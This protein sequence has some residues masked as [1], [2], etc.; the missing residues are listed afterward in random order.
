[1]NQP[2]DQ[3]ARQR[4]L[5]AELSFAVS[6]PAGSGKTGLLTQRV[7]TL[8]A[9]C[10]NPE[11][12]LSIT[13]TR[14]A[15]AEMQT[16]IYNA[17]L[18]A[19]TQP[20]PDNAYA[21][22]TWDLARTVL[23]VSEQK[24]WQILENKNR[25]RVMTIDGLCRT[26]TQQLPISSGL[27]VNL[28]TCDDPELLYQ[29][30][31][32]G[33]LDQLETSSPFQDSIR[34]LF[35][36]LD[37]NYQKIESLLVTLL[38]NRD[39]WLSHLYASKDEKRYLESVLNS[40]VCET[41]ENCHRLLAPVASDLVLLADY[42]ANGLLRDNK[43]S[44]VSTCK[45]LT[46]LPAPT[47]DNLQ[48]W[49]ALVQFLT[50]DAGTWRKTVNK[51]Q[52]FPTGA[53]KEEKA[54]ASLRKSQFYE[55]ISWCSEQAGLNELLA[56][57]RL[58]PT[59]VYAEHQWAFLDSLTQVLPLLVAQLKVVFNQQKQVD[60]IE[61]TQAALQALGDQDEPTD[62]ALK[63]DYRIQHILVDEFQDTSVAQLR[64][65][66]KLTAGWQPNDG[67]SLFLVGDGMQSCYSFRGANV[68]IFLEARRN[69]IGTTQLE[70]LDLT[71]NFR[72]HESI[73]EWVNQTFDAAFP[74]QDDVNRGAVRYADSHAF[75]TEPL[76]LPA[77]V[78]TYGLI[79]AETRHAEAEQ[80]VTLIKQTQTEAPEET[81]AILVRSRPHLELILRALEA[82]GLSWQAQEIDPLAQRMAIID[83]MSLTRALLD[84]SDRIAW[85]ALLRAPWCGL[86]NHDLFAL[87]HCFSNN[88]SD[89]EQEKKPRDKPTILSQLLRFDALTHEDKQ[90][91]PFSLQAGTALARFTPLILSAWRN[92]FRK[93]LRAS[94]EGLW[95]ALGGPAA[96][97]DQSDIANA[98]RYFDLL[99]A[100]ETGGTIADWERF[101]RAVKR[102][103]ATPGSSANPKLQV[104]TIHKSKG[105]EF[106]S[107]FIPA[108]DARPRADDT[109]LL[110]WQE[111]L[112]AHGNT[113]LLLAPAHAT[114]DDKDSIYQFVANEMRL[115]TQYEATRLLYVGC[116][117]AIRRLHLLAK[118]KRNDKGDWIAPS[119]N[120]LL[121]PIW[122][123]FQANMRQIDADDTSD[124]V[125]TTATAT[126]RENWLRRIAPNWHAP[127]FPSTELLTAFR[128]HEF[129]DDDNLPEREARAAFVAR[130][131]GTV[132]HNLLQQ[133]TEQ[134][135]ANTP[136]DYAEKHP[137]WRFQLAQLGL[138]SDEQKAACHQLQKALDGILSD[139]I[140][141]WLLD[142]RHTA[143]ACEEAI[144]S[145]SAA[146]KAQLNIIDRT[147]IALPPVGTAIASE[148]TNTPCR[149]IIDYKSSALGALPLAEFLEEQ[150]ALYAGQ[151]RRYADLYRQQGEK[152]IRTALY[153][154]LL[155]YFHELDCQN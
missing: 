21:A 16:R 149:W 122:P 133:I 63:L 60:F 108:L 92:R 36:H 72:S 113:D 31:C 34:H 26:L 58:L 79:N 28:D 6:A 98:A 82:A 120:S 13:F 142:N 129:A 107:V 35:Q 70:A 140:G 94:I 65:L 71:V 74:G 38:G 54:A 105:L 123:S 3:A 77:G 143:S 20:R 100:H 126:T 131:T 41:L 112:D 78:S 91:L 115:K 48:L 50:T 154:P 51:T 89:T 130:H 86:N 45:G 139:P 110:L 102:L 12:V 18:D 62:L 144:W 61:I 4:A 155:G 148:L 55:L 22:S 37:N 124:L 99:S 24:H 136:L 49:Q 117:R 53:N 114:G 109:Q 76:A 1:M 101:E 84:P 64:L 134:G 30:A 147:F 39:Q 56:S 8:L 153:F 96:L 59:P 128:G 121:A 2:I 10:D 33:L 146:G 151:L 15:A 17:L 66:E 46:E 9:R 138:S 44:D 42:A 132:L 69:G 103:Y 145:V 68:G 14:K 90:Q 104:M 152:P 25:L 97:L 135:L 81:I 57:I 118:V 7:L 125:D 127:A 83:L 150:A 11:E 75:Q 80:L 141:R 88:T 5:N 27:G 43:V 93:T 40:I 87:V 119:S 67:R 52:G 111:R 73:V 23:S 85:L 29:L 106:D 95:L 47:P 32:K 116:T 19:A 137:F